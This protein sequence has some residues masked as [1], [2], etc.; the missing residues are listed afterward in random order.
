MYSAIF[1]VKA[2]RMKNINDKYK[3][4]KDK[5]TGYTDN[6]IRAYAEADG[7][8]LN[9]LCNVKITGLMYDGVSCE[10]LEEEL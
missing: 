4:D 8:Y 6:Y 2:N 3:T 10:I 5:I 9:T 1:K 7:K